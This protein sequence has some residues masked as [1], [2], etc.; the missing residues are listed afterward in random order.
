MDVLHL[1]TPNG[2]QPTP[3]QQVIELATTKRN[4]RAARQGFTSRVLIDCDIVE[5]LDLIT[6]YLSQSLNQPPARNYTQLEQ[7]IRELA[8]HPNQHDHL[9]TWAHAAE[10]LI[11][12]PRP[13]P[14]AKCANC[15]NT[16][17]NIGGKQKP[18]L[19]LIDGTGDITCRACYHTV[20][21]T[22]IAQYK[23]LKGV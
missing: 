7:Q 12:P 20:H 21:I 19:A 3:L 15:D 18:A 16:T 8:T 4:D 6:S 23:Q 1:I 11:N 17:L 10:A 13:I 22:E 5:Y 2:T 9:I 14:G